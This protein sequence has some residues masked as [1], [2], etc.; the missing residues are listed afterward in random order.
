LDLSNLSKP[1]SADQVEFRVQSINNGGYA[2]LLVY[3][4]ARC[5]QNRLDEVCG[6]LNWQRSHFRDNA[7]CVVSIRNPETGEWIA[8]EDTGSESNTEA[9]KGLASDSFKRACFNWGIGRELYDYPEI[10]VKLN[11]NEFFL[12]EK[13]KDRNGKPK[14]TATWELK[15][16]KWRWINM[17]RDDGT[18]ILLRAKDD[19]GNVRFNYDARTDQEKAKK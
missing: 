16:K 2:L 3:K 5:D 14:A 11:K 12:N 17:F 15:L 19:K 18:L 8:K 9:A 4:D 13:N 10:S 1:L 7:N 6:P